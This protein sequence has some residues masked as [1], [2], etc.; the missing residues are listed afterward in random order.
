[1]DLLDCVPVRTASPNEEWA[2][3]GLKRSVAHQTDLAPPGGERLSLRHAHLSPHHT[4]WGSTATGRGDNV[5]RASILENVRDSR[6][7]LGLHIIH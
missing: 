2:I 5:L 1:M 3:A 6:V 4:P 7:V